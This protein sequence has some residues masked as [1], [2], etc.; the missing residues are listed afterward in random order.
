M[1]KIKPSLKVKL[2][3]EDENGVISQSF[4]VT[5]RELTRRQSRTINEDSKDIIGLFN[6]SQSTS[7][8]IE[9]LENKI[10]A[11]KELG[12]NKD[13]VKFT[14]QLDKLY[15]VQDKQEDEFEVLGGLDALLD[16]S[17]ATF[18]L[19]IGGKDKDGLVDFIEENSDYN[20][21]LE[22][23]ALDAKEQLGK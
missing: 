22:A 3:I 15:A 20:T 12:N 21:V 7:K 11:L 18:L 9:S 10:D 1:A 17:K 16:A 14:T 6:D 5:Y 13:V 23:L 4:N 2:D 19:S 8:R